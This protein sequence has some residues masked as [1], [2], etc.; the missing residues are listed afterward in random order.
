MVFFVCKV[1][2]FVVVFVVVLVFILVVVV[3]EFQIE[4]I[5]ELFVYEDV[6]CVNIWDVVVVSEEFFCFDQGF[7]FDQFVFVLD[8]EDIDIDD[9]VFFFI[10]WYLFCFFLLLFVLL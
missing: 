9:V 2:F 5:Y 6:F 7:F 10:V 4:F 1:V 3:F 8:E